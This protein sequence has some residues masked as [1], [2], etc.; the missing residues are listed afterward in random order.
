[1]SQADFLRVVALE[2][3][4]EDLERLVRELQESKAD[5]AGRKPNQDKAA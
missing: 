3:R 4:V 2:K 1:M 5:R